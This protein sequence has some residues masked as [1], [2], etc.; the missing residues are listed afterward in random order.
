MQYCSGEWFG[1]GCGSPLSR[2]RFAHLAIR[3]FRLDDIYLLYRL[4]PRATCLLD[5]QAFLSLRSSWV[6]A[7]L[8]LLPGGKQQSATYVLRQAGHGLVH[9]GFVQ[10][11]RS[12][13]PRAGKLLCLGPSLDDP[14]GHPAIWNKLLAYCVHQA[15]ACGFD[16]LYADVPD[17]PLLLQTLATVGFEP[18]VHQT[19]WRH[20]ARAGTTSGEALS[21]QP[22]R[23]VDCWDLW[24][25]YRE[26]TPGLVRQAEGVGEECGPGERFV[27][28]LGLATGEVYLMRS[29]G[30]LTGAFH[31]LEGSHGSWLRVW[32]AWCQPES[33]PLRRL[34]EQILAVAQT[35]AAPLYFASSSYQGG[36]GILLEELGFVPLVDRVRLVKPLV[37]WVRHR[38]ALFRPAAETANEIVPSLAV[39]AAESCPF[40]ASSWLANLGHPS[41]SIQE[42][43]CEKPS[44]ST[45]VAAPL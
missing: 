15:A 21:V 42:A 5:D 39:P 8:S 32:T 12:P 17:Q 2:V 25:L 18:F 28:N 9:E 35:S 22:C 19:V 36:V 31:L 30:T 29:A 20:P 16:R 43:L 14:S 38:T 34:F 23:P 4:S 13:S 40:S 10:L 33:R 45:S 3:P 27:Q 1:K 11:G 24:Q 44:R 37:R 41:L 26:S 6:A 7:L